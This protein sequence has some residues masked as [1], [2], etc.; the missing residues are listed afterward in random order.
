MHVDIYEEL[1]REIAEWQTDARSGRMKTRYD[2]VDKPT[3]I[4]VSDMTLKHFHQDCMVNARKEF[5]DVALE[6]EAGARMIFGNR[7]GKISETI[8][9][10]V[11]PLMLPA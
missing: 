5:S 9:S 2:L 3:D 10:P 11:C 8:K 4:G 1:G 7:A 6:H